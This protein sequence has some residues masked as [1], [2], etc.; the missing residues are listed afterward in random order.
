MKSIA[1]GRIAITP[2]EIDKIAAKTKI[3]ARALETKKDT[4]TTSAA[5]KGALFLP[6]SRALFRVIICP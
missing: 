3:A 5:H 1:A 4:L 2:P 6:P